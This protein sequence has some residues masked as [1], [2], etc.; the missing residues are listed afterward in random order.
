MEFYLYKI[1]N[2][3]DGKIYIGQSVNPNGRWRR[4]KSDA[5]LGKSKSHLSRA[6]QKYGV[7]N[8]TFEVIVQ[9]KTLEDIDEAEIICIKQYNSSNQNYGYNIALGGNGKR[10]ISEQTKRKISKFRTGKKASEETKNRMSQSMVGKNAGEKNG[11]FGKKSSHAKLTIEQAFE[12]RREYEIGDISIL[13][14]AIKY[15]VSKKTILN[16]VHNRIYKG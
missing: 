16:I 6:I 13:K 14:L 7:Q 8:F 12:I 10:I 3:F 2:V 4:H 11:M 9:A 5:K 1:T 15:S